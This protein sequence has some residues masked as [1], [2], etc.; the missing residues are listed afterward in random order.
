MGYSQTDYLQLLLNLLPRG[1]AW[2][3]D[4]STIQYKL[5]E[6]FSYELARIDLRMAELLVER[7][8]RYTEELITDHEDDLGLPDEC[9]SLATA[10]ADR[11]VNAHAK[12]VA[13]GGLNEQ[14]YMDFAD[15]LGLSITIDTFTPFWSGLGASGDPCGDQT[16]IFYWC[17]NVTYELGDDMDFLAAARCTFEKYKPAHTVLIWKYVGGGFNGGFSTGFDRVPFVV[18]SGFSTGF[19]RGFL[20]DHVYY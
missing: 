5:M 7:D 17:I 14:I 11:R 4:P 8:P 2:S 3:R 19:D 13:E 6:A 1:K 20:S 9:T 10:L 12:Y 18:D 16:N 15:D